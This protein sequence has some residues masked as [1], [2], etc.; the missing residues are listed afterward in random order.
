MDQ[1]REV[2]RFHHYAYSTEKSYVDWILRYIRFNDRK[3]PKDMGKAEIERFLSHLAINRDVAASTQNQ[4]LNAILFLYREVLKSP[5]VVQ[6]RALRS[7]KPR[8]LPTVLSKNEMSRVLEN[9]PARHLLMFQFMYGC[10]LRVLEVLRLRTHDFDFENSQLY[11]RDSKGN[12]DRMT[13]FPQQLHNDIKMQI[14]RVKVQHDRDLARGFGLVVLPGALARK[15]PNAAKSFGWQYAFPASKNCKDPRSENIVR[16]HL[17]KTVLRKSLNSAIKKTG[18]IKHVSSHVFR[19]SFATH[20]LEDGVN[21][22]TIQ[23]LLGHKDIRTTEVYTHV[24]DKSFSKVKS[25]LE[26]LSW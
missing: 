9:I 15:Y 21:I 23:T 22:R 14:D 18:I 16:H 6:I 2:L 10:G 25:P 4:A 20:L 3:H 17:H 26:T 19:H 13:L 5:L 24:M 1:V 8:R 7:T 12:K 11:I